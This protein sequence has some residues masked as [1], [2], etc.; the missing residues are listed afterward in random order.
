MNIGVDSDNKMLQIHDTLEIIFIELYTYTILTYDVVLRYYYFVGD[1]HIKL[2]IIFL[3]KLQSLNIA[4]PA[5]VPF[6]FKPPLNDF[7]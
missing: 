1:P 4:R 3:V 5:V 2:Q 6:F 7:T